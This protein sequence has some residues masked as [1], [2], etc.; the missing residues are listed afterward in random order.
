MYNRFLAVRKECWEK[1]KKSVSYTQTS[2]MLTQLKK[3]ISWLNEA[4]SIAL[5]QSL[6]NLDTAYQNFLKHDRGYPKI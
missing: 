1:D 3:E 2:S 5:Q 6:R 4:D